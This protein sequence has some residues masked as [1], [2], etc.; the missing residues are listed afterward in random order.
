MIYL[1]ILKLVYSIEIIQELGN[2][3]ISEKNTLSLNL[4]DYFQGIDLNYSI[5][6]TSEYSSKITLQ[7]K[8][9]FEKRSE[10]RLL[11]SK[12]TPSASIFEIISFSSGY[13]SYLFDFS[14]DSLL[15]FEINLNSGGIGAS[16]HDIIPSK[17]ANYEILGIVLLSLDSNQ[18]IIVYGNSTNISNFPTNELFI[19]NVTSPFE[20]R[21]YMPLSMPNL[22]DMSNLRAHRTFKSQI[23]AFYGTVHDQGQVVLYNFTNISS[24]SLLQIITT[25]YSIPETPQ[26]LMCPQAAISYSTEGSQQLFI[27][28]STY[29]LISY[30]YIDEFVESSILDLSIYGNCSAMKGMVQSFTGLYLLLVSCESGMVVLNSEI[31]SE[32]YM[33]PTYSIQGSP[34]KPMGIHS[35]SDYFYFTI[36]VSAGEMALQVSHI[37]YPR[38]PISHIGVS[39]KGLS[40]QGHWTFQTG[41]KDLFYLRVDAGVLR[42]YKVEVRLPQIKMEAYDLICSV[43]AVDV[44]GQAASTQLEISVL[45]NDD[46][47][48]ISNWYKGR[49]FTENVSIEYTFVD[50]YG[51]VELPVYMFSGWNQ[52]YGI[53]TE[54]M[55]FNRSLFSIQEVPITKFQYAGEVSTEGFVYASLVKGYIALMNNTN[56]RLVD[57]DTGNTQDFH[58]KNSEKAISFTGNDK[59]DY[60]LIVSQCAVLSIFTIMDASGILPSSL[61]TEI[62]CKFLEVISNFMICGN[63][64]ILNIYKVSGMGENTTFA[65]FTQFIPKTITIKSITV[66][67]NFNSIESDFLYVGTE[68]QVGIIDLD[69]LETVDKFTN[70]LATIDIVKY[71][72]LSASSNQLYIATDIEIRVYD[73][74]LLLI[75]SIPVKSE[76]SMTVLDNFL[77]VMSE[78][79]FYLIDGLQDYLV[80]SVY[81]STN[82][83]EN[84][85]GAMYSLSNIT[86]V[87]TSKN[88]TL[89]IYET[90]CPVQSQPCNSYIPLNITLINPSILL[91]NLNTVNITIYSQNPTSKV[92]YPVQLLLVTYGMNIIEFGYGADFTV[93]YY[94]EKVYL[95]TDFMQGDDMQADLY[96]NSQLVTNSSINPVY[97]QPSLDLKG[98]NSTGYILLYQS[99]IP[100]T[101]YIVATTSENFLLII[102][103][104]TLEC[105]ARFNL[106]E[107]FSYQGLS[108]RSVSF[109]STQ[110][111][112][113][114]IV[115]TCTYIEEYPS[116]GLEDCS[117]SITKPV[118]IAVVVDLDQMN[119]TLQ[120]SIPL[121]YNCELLK[122]IAGS[123]SLFAVLVVD[124]ILDGS[125][126]NNH[127]L[128]YAGDWNQSAIELVFVESIN[129]YS[130]G[131]DEFLAVSLDGYYDFTYNLTIFVIDFWYGIR[132]L[133][134]IGLDRMEVIDSIAISKNITSI[135]LCGS[136]LYL[137]YQDTSVSIY[138]VRS[139]WTL[140]YSMVYYAYNNATA[141]YTALRGF[142]ECNEYYDTQYIT[143]P[144]ISTTSFVFRVINLNCEFTSSV[145]RDIRVSEITSNNNFVGSIK[146][147]NSD[148]LIAIEPT[149]GMISSYVL[150]DFNFVIQELSNEEYLEMIQYWGS[151]NF[152]SQMHIYNG[153]T[154]YYSNKVNIV[155]SIEES[156]KTGVSSEPGMWWAWAMGG[157]LLVILICIVFIVYRFVWRKRMLN[158]HFH[159]LI[160]N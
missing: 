150:Q 119:I 46:Y 29:G 49:N 52:T 97:L 84:V 19:V 32:L 30:S 64:A 91:E 3:T 55:E 44:L 118:M 65:L 54:T 132:V 109:V 36:P 148:T 6:T 50:A 93:D 53:D 26:G 146:F 38:S 127:I 16:W 151:P 157:G 85:L 87:L 133:N 7:D 40:P 158:K 80:D 106:T 141:Q 120:S 81:F 75:R 101:N 51:S 72:F 4:T 159:S 68:N 144:M 45:H 112:C 126:V 96:L 147:V 153:K 102:N 137:G 98:V 70:F 140:E 88:D 125:M 155:R 117:N 124:G 116:Y 34:V 79:V 25:Y 13:K 39:Y 74:N 76:D 15:C 154:E 104:T 135:G 152:T 14:D 5:I 60:F 78:S 121:K 47:Y 139:D 48:S 21:E 1:V 33:I 110:S 31:L 114:L 58:V 94:D 61:S 56:L 115:A 23:A 69:L 10:K 92:T 35:F 143:L 86:Y 149:L 22:T 83:K 160:I 66:T 138:V 113:I 17:N 95:I 71:R 108:C 130:L 131:L 111:P 12:S 28:D 73:S 62:N 100:N 77:F 2:I 11:W 41:S 27:L 9:T 129:F 99:V 156:S 89:S 18:F 123:D 59:N 24:P 134:T 128:R 122:V 90:K 145:L 67:R 142:I 136:I 57:A 43:S 8:I 82:L 37:N 105:Q 103:V 107:S 42:I 63:N 20:A